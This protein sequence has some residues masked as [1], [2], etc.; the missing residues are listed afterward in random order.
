MQYEYI[1]KGS[2]DCGKIE[3]TT[4]INKKYLTKSK[5]VNNFKCHDC[6]KFNVVKIIRRE[7]DNNILTDKVL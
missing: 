5:I 1:F 4:G 3:F 7:I 2:C 6:G